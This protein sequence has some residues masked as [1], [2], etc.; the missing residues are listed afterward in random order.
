MKKTTLAF[1]SILMFSLLAPISAV[2]AE[3]QNQALLSNPTATTSRPARPDFKDGKRI[4]ITDAA[5]ENNQFV[6]KKILP[7]GKKEVK[8]EEF[9]TLK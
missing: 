4:I 3:D 1:S 5:L 6:I 9:N 7:E 2:L 8:W